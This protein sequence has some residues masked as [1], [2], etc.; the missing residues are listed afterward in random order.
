MNG[1]HKICGLLHYSCTPVTS[2]T[3]VLEG[4]HRATKEKFVRR[5]QKVTEEGNEVE[6]D[7]DWE[8]MTEEEMQDK[9]WSEMLRGNPVTML[10]LVV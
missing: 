10:F 4:L 5:V 3:R 2:V 7:E 9:G 8:F 1:L 6:V